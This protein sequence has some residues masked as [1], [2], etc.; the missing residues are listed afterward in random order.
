MWPGLGTQYG[1]LLCLESSEHEGNCRTERSHRLIMA[2]LAMVQ[3]MNCILK[4]KR[5]A[6]QNSVSKAVK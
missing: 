2:L 1:R 3:I 6:L 5:R 4:G